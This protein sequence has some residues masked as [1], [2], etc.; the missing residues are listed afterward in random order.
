MN[1]YYLI[2]KCSTSDNQKRLVKKQEKKMFSFWNIWWWENCCIL[3]ALSP[4][5][6]LVPLC[7]M[8][9]GTLVFP[10]TT[11]LFLLPPL[12]REHP[13]LLSTA[14]LGLSLYKH[15][16]SV[17]ITA[18]FLRFPTSIFHMIPT[19]SSF[20]VLINQ[21]PDVLLLTT[22]SFLFLFT[23]TISFYSQGTLIGQL[24]IS[25]WYDE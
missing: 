20:Q 23:L 14:P 12:S 25:L 19:C 6:R 7:C 13:P 9:P 21:H 10:S 24:K 17:Q 18:W 4:D 22:V 5:P 11:G 1:P 2:T 16:F 15:S 3:P 8:L